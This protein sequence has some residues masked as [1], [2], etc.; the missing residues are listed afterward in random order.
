MNVFNK[1]TL[2]VL[3][4]NKVRTLVTIIGIILSA[5]ML[6]A[7]TTS[8]S[9]LQKFLVKVSIEKDGNW[10]G[11]V[12]DV[13]KSQIDEL[14]NDPEVNFIT[15]MKNIGYARL[16]ESQ[17]EYKPYL[18]IG[19]MSDNFCDIIPVNLK[20]GRLPANSAEII[21]PEHLQTSGGI[22]FSIGDT[23]SLDIGNRVADGL[24]LN[25][26]I[27]YLPADGEITEELKV[28]K[29]RTYTVVG[30]YERPG[31]ESYSAPGFTA[32]TVDDVAEEGKYDVYINM[33]KPKKIYDLLGNRF[34]GNSC[35]INGDLLRFLGVSDN[36]NFTTVLYG[37]AAVLIVLIMFGSVSLIY[38]AFS[39]SVNE[40]T[41]QFGLLTSIGATRRQLKR[42]V[43]F[44][45]FFLSVIGIPIG[46]LAGMLG[47]AV[48]LRLSRELFLSFLN[49]FTDSILVLSVTP[50]AI[51][52]ATAVGIITVLIS[53]YI[54]VKRAVKISAVD[55]IRQTC[56]IKLP[57]RKVKTSV[58]TY[59]LFGFEGLLARKNFKRNKSKYRA[60]VLSL[61]LSIVLF[62]SASS[63][64][65]Y[66]MKSAG[67]LVS[68]SEY[69]II[70]SYTHHESA[71][72]SLQEVFDKLSDISGVL[73][74]GYAYTH[75]GDKIKVKSEFINDAYIDYLN[76]VDSI[77]ANVDES[78]GDNGM[79][80]DNG[81]RAGDNDTLELDVVFY[82]IN[83]ALYEKY[84]NDTGLS[85]NIYLDASFPKAVAA[86]FRKI[87]NESEKRYYT[88]NILKNGDIDVLYEDSKKDKKLEIG[89]VTD[90]KPFCVDS[91]GLT[92]MYPYSSMSKILNKT[93]TDDR[94]VE[95]YF[96]AGK[97]HK[98][99]FNE[100]SRVLQEKGLPTG[101][102][103]DLAES[104]EANRA[105]ISVI[106]I[107]SYGFIVLI[108]LIAAANVFNTIS[109][110]IGLR[111][112][113]FAMLK[114]I[115]MTQKGFNKMMNF[116]CLL[117]GFKGLLY[118]I[119]ASIGVTYFIYRSILE[120]WEL[121]FFIPW[122]SVVIAVGSVFAVVFATMVYSMNKM[123]KD[124]PIDALKN[125]NL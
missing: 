13:D 102:L 92:L 69:D 2:R 27:A 5:A 61:F 42:S 29:Q 35:R 59:K 123:K 63:F 8:V 31:F 37:L 55:A 111:R 46:I 107:F 67:S 23:L 16:L 114:S 91:Y 71:K 33:K 85:R 117:Y 70:Y 68:D 9:S 80:D 15:T 26:N 94:D 121:N 99:V 34:S 116:E 78:S 83:D 10:H 45:A 28:N 21:L 108:S 51:I 62:I 17:N 76:S 106:N 36:E 79:P 77:G 4:K 64:C 110:N 72:A 47:I 43:L 113:E 53:A 38:N 97:N 7:V 32:L 56:D 95:I 98:T 14:S 112:R 44:E 89:V 19:G 49:G 18:F 50:G 93:R 75:Y 24:V 104:A 30:F 103:Y 22:T 96:K 90:K 82:F 39:I 86:D 105:L 74:A 12:F 60:T 125:E 11:A 81:T 6:T 40:R 3:L 48:T 84:L 87:Y 115:G 54:P 118:G 122:Y 88:F 20:E 58:L 65:A 25:Q 109:T 119:P 57:A 52:A 1:I 101:S 73:E 66:L 120:G 100:I 124:N 41:Q